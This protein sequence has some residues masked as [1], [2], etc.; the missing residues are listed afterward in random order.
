MIAHFPNC[1]SMV[2]SASFNTCSLLDIVFFLKSVKSFYVV[3]IFLLKTIARERERLFFLCLLSC[4]FVDLIMVR[5]LFFYRSRDILE[6]YL[7]L[8]IS[9]CLAIKNDSIT[10]RQR[11][12]SLPKLSVIRQKN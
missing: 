8:S 2:C 6:T 3:Q 4:F 10:M 1:F 11:G 9:L 7:A 12:N 5:N